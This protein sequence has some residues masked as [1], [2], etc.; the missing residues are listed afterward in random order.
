MMSKLAITAALVTVLYAVSALAR[1]VPVKR[2]HH[3]WRQVAGMSAITLAV[4]GLACGVFGA[5]SRPAATA[6]TEGTVTASSA[7]DAATASSTLASLPADTAAASDSLPVGVYAPGEWNSW[8]PVQQFSQ[9]IGEPVHYVL[10]YLGPDEPFPVQLGKLA[11]EHGTEPVLQ[12]LPTM[13]M[14]NIAAGKDDA[15]LHSLAG[16]V[17]SYGHQ[18]VLSFAPEANGNWYQYGWTRT[19]PA[20]YQAAWRHVLAEF[21]DVRNVTWMDTVNINYPGSGPLADYVIPG[22][23]I[24]LDG[25]YGLNSGRNSFKSVFGATL[26]QVRVDTKSPVMISETSVETSNGQAASIPDLVKSA[27]ANHLAGL[28]WFNQ[29][30][31]AGQHWTL[32]SAGAAAL[33]ASLRP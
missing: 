23:M 20:D 5:T 24:G 7:A 18:V 25:Y 32:T 29:D 26:D 2:R 14:A 16:Q 6:A 12:M 22:V 21:K 19:P 4:L 31:G 33:R 17:S 28:I 10:D 9:E 15:Y 8:S 11:A 3:N 1:L 30:K 27:K 13:S